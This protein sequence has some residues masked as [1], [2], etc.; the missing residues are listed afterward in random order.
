MDR[1]MQRSGAD[2]LTFWV[3]GRICLDLARD[4]RLTG[5]F[6]PSVKARIPYFT[7]RR[8][9]HL[10]ERDL[11][12]LSSVASGA[13]V[14][15]GE[16]LAA[17]KSLLREAASDQQA[18]TDAYAAAADIVFELL[19]GPYR[20]EGGDLRMQRYP[21]AINRLLSWWRGSHWFYLHHFR[22]LGY[23]AIA[24]LPP[25]RGVDTLEGARSLRVG[26]RFTDQ[27][28]ALFE[29]EFQ[30]LTPMA[31]EKRW[32][33]WRASAL[34]SS[35]GGLGPLPHGYEREVRAADRD[36]SKWV[37]KVEQLVGWPA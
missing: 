32:A 4:V 14:T 22:D 15:I 33:A 13:P 28:L 6:H 31:D 5:F 21:R 26:G 12:V 18:R 9:R 1:A 3:T 27:E 36:V 11:E 8:F 37:T 25:P 10:M 24:A 19:V 16:G 2:Q 30:D 17:V 23:K 34:P 7:D 29:A 35:E 20:F